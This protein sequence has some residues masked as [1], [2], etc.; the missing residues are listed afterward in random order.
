MKEKTIYRGINVTIVTKHLVQIE[1]PSKLLEILF[2]KYVFKHQTY[3]DLALEYG[4]TKR[5]AYDQ[6]HSYEVAKKEHNPRAVTLLCDTTFYGKRKDKLATV[7]FCD[8]IENEVLLW[9]H[10]DSEKS[11]YYKEMLQQLLSL[12]Y[13]V[14]AVTIDGK[15]GL[16]TVKVCPIQMCHFHQKKIVD[17]YIVNPRVFC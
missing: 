4:K 5:W 17:R 6:I 3:A 2:Y 12:G 16:N 8:T 10:V 15:R 11:K 1:R 7:V 14:N 13:T 9:R